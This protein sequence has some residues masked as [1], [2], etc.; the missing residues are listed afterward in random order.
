[1]YQLLESENEKPAPSHFYSGS[2]WGQVEL[3]ACDMQVTGFFRLPLKKQAST[4]NPS[5]AIMALVVRLRYTNG[6]TWWIV[7]SPHDPADCEKFAHSVSA[8]SH[9]ALRRKVGGWLC[10]DPVEVSGSLWEMFVCRAHLKEAS[11]EERKKWGPAAGLLALGSIG[12]GACLEACLTSQLT[13][14]DIC[15]SKVDAARSAYKS[16]AKLAV[17]AMKPNCGSEAVAK[18]PLESH[19]SFWWLLACWMTQMTEKFQKSQL[20][21][22]VWA[23]G[24]SASEELLHRGVHPKCQGSS[25]WSSTMW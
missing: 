4:R 22:P 13:G 5:D 24:R 23:Q 1:M 11:L 21:P 6:K 25:F 20:L 10:K 2:M 8:K 3:K 15:V 7:C 18:R 19:K 12:Q 16:V 9:E 17:A 14:V